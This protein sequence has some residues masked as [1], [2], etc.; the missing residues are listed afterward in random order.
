M[1]TKK[2]K[3]N[4]ASKKPAPKKQP[5]K[6]NKKPA[7]AKPATGKQRD[8]VQV[9]LK[10]HKDKNRG[11]HHII[12]EDFEDKHVSVGLTTKKTKGKN[13]TRKNYP[14]E[15]DPLGKGK[16]SFM[17]RQGTVDL[18]SNYDTR[19]QKGKM[20]PKDYAKAKEYGDKAKNKYIEKQKK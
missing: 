4:G 9:R 8:L 10:R 13:S 3:K 19:E 7:A 5:T 15:V 16:D 20:S 2:S 17:R 1:S 12:L 6:T 11:H 14:C 18:M